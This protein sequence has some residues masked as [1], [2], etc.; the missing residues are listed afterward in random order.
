MVHHVLKGGGG[1]AEAE[2]HNHRFIEAVLCFER[3]FMLVS[4]FDP[5]LVKAPF[6]I[7]FGENERV[8]YFC[9]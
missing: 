4:V 7:K 8:L 6:Y 5:H 9:D 1:I 2:I 3:R